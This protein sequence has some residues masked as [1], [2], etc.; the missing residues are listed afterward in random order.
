M[1]R[2]ACLF[3][4]ALLIGSAGAEAAGPA[5]P[6]KVHEHMLGNGLK[7]MVVPFDSPGV[8][9]FNTVVR[10]GSRDEI[11]AGHSGF[12]HFFE[13]MM[14]R[15]TPKYSEK[16]YN[17]V[18]KRM[19]ADSNAFTSD[20]RTHYYIIGP[21]AA[22]ETMIDIESDRFQH[23][24]YSEEVFRREA[25]AVLGEYNKNASNPSMP[26]R[27]RMRDLAFSRHTYKHTTM[28]FLADIKAMPDYYD[29]SL[30][31]FKRFYRPENCIVL[32]V[33]DAQPDAVFKLA[34]K[35]YG[36]WSPGYQAPSIPVEPPPTGPQEDQLTW[37]GPVRP[38][39]MMGYRVPAFDVTSV[40]SAAMVMIGEMLFGESAPL[41]RKLV[42]DKQW[43]D[44]IS[45]GYSL[46]RDPYLFTV[47]TRIK[48]ADK[49]GPVRDEIAAHLAGLR[50][51]P[52]DVQRLQGIK[53]YLYYNFASGLT[54]PGAAAFA[55]SRYLVLTG[56]PQTINRMF[57]Q[58]ERV[59]PADI[60]RVARKIFR[61][62]GRTTVQ[63]SN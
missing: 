45:G 32:V 9:S 3:A 61:E 24:Q 34:G 18:L 36:D 10:T 43:V 12:A 33:G 13:H 23:L 52:V 28:G 40:D 55:L 21:S 50:D 4:G 14:F 38:H 51:Q 47:F 63:L 17:D 27:E 29:Y 19:G 59:T 20:D 11:E 58:Y 25:L 8:V 57:E 60:Q 53:S 48:S 1:R 37:P 41:Y 22:L 44:T 26:M 62:D 31:F 5:F 54:S 56:E 7:V 2:T 49:V 30:S 6:F 16:A 35:Y 42:V 46:H 39:I 15:G